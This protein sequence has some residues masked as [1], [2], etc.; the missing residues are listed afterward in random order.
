[1]P[2]LRDALERVLHLQPQYSSNATT[3]AMIERRGLLLGEVVPALKDKVAQL[4]IDPAVEVEGS[5]GAG[6]AAKV[7]WARLFDREQSPTPRSGWYLVYL[8]AAD[9]S[10]VALSL[11]QGVTE[12]PASDI[13]RNVSRA[14]RILATTPPTEAPESP[15]APTETIALRDSG[16][17]R[18]YEAGHVLGFS[19]EAGAVPSDE[20]LAQDLRWLLERL[21]TVSTLAKSPTVRQSTAETLFSVDPEAQALD[22][23]CRAIL[24]DKEDV[25]VLFE[26]LMDASPQIVLNGPPGTGKTFVA[27]HLAAYL[28][29]TP[30]QIANNPYIEVV[31]FHPSYG[32]EEFV[33]GL[34]PVPGENGALALAPVPGVL[35]RMVDEMAADGLPRVL[36]ID[37]MNRANLP[38]VFGEMMLLLEY[39]DQ[40]VRLMYRDSFSLPRNLYIIG[41]MN[42]A[43]RSAKN[44]D[45]AL[46]RRFDFFR[47]MPDA[48]ILRRHYAQGDS[49]N[50]VGEELYEGF[51]ALNTAL[52]ATIGA[53]YQVGHSYLMHDEMTVERLR[54]TWKYQLMPLLEDYFQ[55]DPATLEEFDLQ[56]FWPSA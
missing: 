38:R 24:W 30:G 4:P 23:L 19:Y 41:T 6:N 44:I 7:P 20:I 40:D 8:F 16:L 52:T 29:E 33:E 34:R 28:L 11:N 32:Y 56:R 49:E 48:R 15:S 55:D 22:V 18:K 53:D 2:N 31:Q 17:G 47:V 10:S 51:V 5:S 39:R 1:M 12:L 42:T 26:G 9:G 25:G 21:Q 35:V 36:I 50:L 13:A 14:R 43:D 27:Q 37:E 45:L 3:P 54:H 46:R